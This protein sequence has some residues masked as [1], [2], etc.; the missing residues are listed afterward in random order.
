MSNIRQRAET[1]SVDAARRVIGG[2]VE[3]RSAD[4]SVCS[5]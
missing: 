3:D 5:I 4:T 2:A 1:L